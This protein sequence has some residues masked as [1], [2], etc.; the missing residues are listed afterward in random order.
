MTDGKEITVG[1]QVLLPETPLEGAP[2]E[3]HRSPSEQIDDL[4]NEVK[5]YALASLDATQTHPDDQVEAYQRILGRVFNHE[6]NNFVAMGRHSILLSRSAPLPRDQWGPELESQLAASFRENGTKMRQV[7]EYLMNPTAQRSTDID[8]NAIFDDETRSAYIGMF[9]FDDSLYPYHVMDAQSLKTIVRGLHNVVSVFTAPREQREKLLQEITS[10]TVSVGEF[11][12]IYPDKHMYIVH[13]DLERKL[14]Q[15]ELNLLFEM[16][17]NA[18]KY[19]QSVDEPI[20]ILVE[21]DRIM[22]KN[23]TKTGGDI[24]DAA[25]GKRGVESE[26]QTGSGFGIFKMKS[27]AGINGQALEYTKTSLGETPDTPPFE[28]TCTLKKAA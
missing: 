19:K 26:R 18:K 25:L 12:N 21:P 10:S 16:L 2:E 15:F 1:Q 8:I 5:K 11:M 3:V 27:I 22:V 28:V 9:L 4:L 14:N 6:I 17:H 23:K 24:D 20:E 13:G 7:V